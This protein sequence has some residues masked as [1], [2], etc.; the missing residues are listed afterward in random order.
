M[1][2]PSI[3]YGTRTKVY[4]QISGTGAS[5][6]A[7]EFSAQVREISMAGGDSETEILKTMNANEIVWNHPQDPLEV[8]LVWIYTDPQAFEAVAGGSDAVTRIDAGSYPIIVTGQDTRY[9]HRVWVEASGTAADDWKIRL[10]W[11]DA[12]GISA[13][14]SI[15]AE[16]YIEETVRF[17]CKAGD[18]TEEWTGSYTTAPVSTLANY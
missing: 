11:N 17:K 3:I 8:E 13:E 10:L 6:N 9:K 12:Y 4:V 15:D 14:K 1:T 18:Y 5:T 16:G 7:Q 2:A